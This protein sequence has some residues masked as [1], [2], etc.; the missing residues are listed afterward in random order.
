MMLGPR[1]SVGKSEH[2]INDFRARLKN[3]RGAIGSLKYAAK[4]I[5]GKDKGGHRIRRRD[6]YD[7]KSRLLK[8][9]SLK[10]ASASAPSPQPL[11]LG[12]DL[13]PLAP[14]QK[15]FARSTAAAAAAAAASVALKP[16]FNVNFYGVKVEKLPDI[17]GSNRQKPRKSTDGLRVARR[18]PCDFNKNAVWEYSQSGEWVPY[19][20]EVANDLE[21][22]FA[23]GQVVTQLYIDGIRYDFDFGRVD[24][25]FRCVERRGLMKRIR[26]R[27]AVRHG[28]PMVSTS[29]AYSSVIGEGRPVRTVRERFNAGEFDSA[30]EAVYAACLEGAFHEVRLFCRQRVPNK[31]GPCIPWDL[32]FQRESDGRSALHGAAL[33]SSTVKSGAGEHELAAEALIFYG[34][35]T[36]LRDV[37][38]ATPLHV[39]AQQGHVHMVALLLESGANV[40]ERKRAPGG[41]NR[42]NPADL[43]ASLMASLNWTIQ[44]RRLKSR[45]R[46]MRAT[47]QFLETA[48]YLAAVHNHEHVVA[49]LLHSGANANLVCNQRGFTALLGAVVYNCERSVA[50]LMRGGADPMIETTRRQNAFDVARW[51]NLP[52]VLDILETHQRQR[53]LH[54]T[55]RGH[56]T[57]DPHEFYSEP[58]F[59]IE[60]LKNSETKAHEQ[61]NHLRELYLAKHKAEAEAKLRNRKRTSIPDAHKIYVKIKD[62]KWEKDAHLQ[63]ESERRELERQTAKMLQLVNDAAVSG[64]AAALDAAKN[65]AENFNAKRVRAGLKPFNFGVKS[66]KSSTN[67][68]SK[69]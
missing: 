13:Y 65:Q 42:V 25:E 64:S 36:S 52:T 38:G 39:A 6:E 45:T 19:P 55:P 20:A 50:V 31:E 37:H 60:Y 48:L 35:F 34:A 30:E 8:H 54:R 16:R 51:Q 40:D 11:G 67:N 7:S 10:R 62:G 3:A 41:S 14:D 24:G 23:S 58:R 57:I 44:E 56:S 28:L 63:R 32:N 21:V 15:S 17:Y 46:D 69:N 61:D 47:G 33:A 29:Y 4:D 59:V 1:S 49:K 2:D 22:T 43:G 27:R 26:V 18:E 9:S 66:S 68:D 5:A 12:R 53:Q